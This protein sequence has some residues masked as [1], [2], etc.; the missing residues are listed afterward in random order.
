MEKKSVKEMRTADPE[1]PVERHSDGFSPSRSDSGKWRRRRRW[2]LDASAVAV[3]FAV[4]FVFAEGASVDDC[5]GVRYAYR[6]RGLDLV[7]VPRQPRQ[8]KQI[9]TFNQ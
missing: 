6:E 8:G 7:N 4:F 2:R 9:F 5:H 3:V 1:K